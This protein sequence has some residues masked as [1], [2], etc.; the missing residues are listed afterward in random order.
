MS[1]GVYLTEA[2]ILEIWNTKGTETGKACAARMGLSHHTVSGIRSGRL[3]ANVT[4]K[5]K[6]LVR[7]PRP[8]REPGERKAFGAAGPERFASQSH[9]LTRR[10]LLIARGYPQHII[11][12]SAA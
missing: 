12:G 3:Y 8:P 11:E 6:A 10:E 7:E 1:S 5:G 9:T 2:Q 4:V